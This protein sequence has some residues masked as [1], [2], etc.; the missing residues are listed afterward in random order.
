MPEFFVCDL[1]LVISV[2]TCPDGEWVPR[3][4]SAKEFL[5]SPFC[6]GSIEIPRTVPDSSDI[7][8]KLRTDN[9]S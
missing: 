2:L 8:R 4:K 7:P 3:R 6:E 5:V 1:S 9:L